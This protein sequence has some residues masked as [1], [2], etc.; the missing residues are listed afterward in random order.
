MQHESEKIDEIVVEDSAENFD[1][2]IGRQYISA[3]MKEKL[4]QV[5]VL[6]VPSEGVRDL[7]APVFPV[8]TEDL[9]K[10]IQDKIPREIK[11]DV[12]IEDKDFKEIAFHSALI[13][14]SSFVVTVFAAPTLVNIISEYIKRRL[15]ANS[16]EKNVKISMTV[17]DKKNVSKNITY[18][19]TVEN[20]SKV[21]EK[22]KEL[23][24]MQK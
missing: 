2:W 17:V 6:L 13:V 9:F 11:V 16:D 24:E 10:F 3:D 23:G 8:C 19:G 4:R 15:F 14:I 21:M 20:F 5:D 12:C 18:E 22:V 1:T 7:K